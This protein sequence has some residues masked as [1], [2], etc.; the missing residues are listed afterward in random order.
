[1]LKVVVNH[2]VRLRANLAVRKENHTGPYREALWK[3]FF[4]DAFYDF[5]G[6]PAALTVVRHQPAKLFLGSVRKVLKSGQIGNV[7]G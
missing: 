2:N 7:P 3:S 6:N 5:L 4:E 1:M